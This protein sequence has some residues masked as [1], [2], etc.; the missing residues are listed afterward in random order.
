MLGTLHV[1]SEIELAQAQAA[2]LAAMNSVSEVERLKKESAAVALQK[3]KED[4]AGGET[5]GEALETY[6]DKKIV[7]RKSLM[8]LLASMSND[9]QPKKK[10]LKVKTNKGLKGQDQQIAQQQQSPKNTNR[11]L[12]WS[13]PGNARRSPG[14]VTL[15]SPQKRGS[16][17]R[18]A[19]SSQRN[20]NRPRGNP[21]QGNHHQS[22]PQ[23]NNGNSNRGRFY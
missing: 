13:P 22:P 6:L 14:Q 18:D 9:N 21:Y 5:I 10:N 3:A 4:A 23:R 2:T 16:E 19:G 20:Q 15:T 7:S 12:A 8:K 17:S 1:E 11:Q